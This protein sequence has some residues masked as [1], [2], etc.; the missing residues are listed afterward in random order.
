MTQI[1]DT[2]RTLEHGTYAVPDV[3]ALLK[4]S[5]RHVRDMVAGSEIPG[6]IRLGRLVRFHKG[7]IH[8]WLTTQAKGGRHSG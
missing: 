4:C 8:D 3:A 5:E 7:I 6:V 2:L 1:A